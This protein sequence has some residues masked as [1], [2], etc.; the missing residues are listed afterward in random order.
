MRA[1]VECRPRIA[2]GSHAPPKNAR[3]HETQAD[4]TGEKDG[5]DGAGAG[6]AG[7]GSEGE[8]DSS[9]GE[10][11]FEPMPKTAQDRAREQARKAEVGGLR[12]CVCLL[13][14][15]VGVCVGGW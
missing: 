8:G 13:G 5:K 3:T 11:E 7:E 4:R 15:G 9:A 2:F 12:V 1:G 6:G 10:E 14:R